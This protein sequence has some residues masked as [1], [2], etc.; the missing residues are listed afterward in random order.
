ML[1][2][3]IILSSCKDSETSPIDLSDVIE[4]FKL[5]KEK[6]ME[7]DTEQA[8]AYIERFNKSLPES[9]VISPDEEQ[10]YVMRDSSF[11]IELPD[12]STSKDTFL[13][14]AQDAYNSLVLFW[15]IHSN[16]DTWKR[17]GIAGGESNCEEEQAA[18]LTMSPDIIK[19]NKVRSKVTEYVEFAN[20]SM[21][22]TSDDNEETIEDEDTPEEKAS[23]DTY[24]EY[25]LDRY[26]PIFGDQDTNLTNIKDYIDEQKKLF[27][28]VIERYNNADDVEKVELMLEA[29]NSCK[30]FEEQT[31]LFNLW[32][33]NSDSL[34]DFNWIMVVGQRLMHAKKYS[35]LLAEIWLKWRVICQTT[36]YGSS[37]DSDIPNSYY[38]AYRKLCYQTVVLHYA[39][40]PDDIYAK[41]QAT[42]F[43]AR[44]NI[45][46]NSAFLFG[47]SAALEF[48]DLMP[49][50]FD[51]S[52]DDDDNEDY[53]SD[54]DEY[55][56]ESDED[57]EV[58]EEE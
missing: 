20:N 45:F 10:M 29:L 13:K 5:S 37:R 38:N 16:F 15:N 27:E 58:S 54:T 43:I 9:E 17:F 22:T 31:S 55:D 52:D 3:S 33:D 53:E 51:I 23:F 28:D 11:Y 12:Y 40:H 21:V 50:K 1:L 24:M 47:N 39:Q 25:L 30:T 4:E 56:E 49:D 57:E 2:F 46:R 18:N 8:F 41:G 35:P 14:E 7:G 36:F 26:L 6:G 44:N 48:M 19:D 34:Y 32:V 42:F